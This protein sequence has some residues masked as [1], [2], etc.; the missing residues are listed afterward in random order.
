MGKQCRAGAMEPPT[1][2]LLVTL[3][4]VVG[5]GPL[6]QVSL[7]K[8]I[9]TFKQV[10]LVANVNVECCKGLLSGIPAVRNTSGLLAEQTRQ[11]HLWGQPL[12]IFWSAKAP[13]RTP[14][15]TGLQS[16]VLRPSSRLSTRQLKN[17]KASC[18][19]R[20]FTLS[21]HSLSDFVIHMTINTH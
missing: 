14:E 2:H 7:H 13:P 10:L 20:K 8:G 4:T 19:S 15:R 16:N 18:C 21:P 5:I 17:S 6:Q 11:A 12:Q 9:Q 3:L 1:A